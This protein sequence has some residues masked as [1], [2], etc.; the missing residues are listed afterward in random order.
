MHT[1]KDSVDLKA[2][3]SCKPWTPNPT[4]K[5]LSSD[6]DMPALSWSFS[7]EGRQYALFRHS[8]LRAS[9]SEVLGG[10]RNPEPRV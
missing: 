1:E 5:A 8:V 6:G 10:F 3:T 9:G 2:T 4:F 7:K